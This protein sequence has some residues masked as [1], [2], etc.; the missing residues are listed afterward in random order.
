MTRGLPGDVITIGILPAA[1]IAIGGAQEHQDLLALTNL[2]AADLDLVRRRPEEGL[3]GTFEANRFFKSIARER[4]IA[5]QSRELVGKACQAVD[6]GA[7]S[8]YG[9]VEACREQRTHQQWGFNF[10]DLA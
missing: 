5:A 9:R 7:N 3:N 4:R 8:V 1:R 2:G 6:G 10:R